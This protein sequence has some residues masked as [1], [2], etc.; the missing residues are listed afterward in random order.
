MDLT[1]VKTGKKIIPGQGGGNCVALRA[2]VVPTAQKQNLSELNQ[3]SVRCT[4]LACA[5]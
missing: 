5:P 2:L 1:D 3:A 4:V